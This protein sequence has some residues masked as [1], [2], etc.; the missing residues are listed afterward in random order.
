ML[1]NSLVNDVDCFTYV[2]YER[3]KF[4]LTD[5]DTAEFTYNG[6][7]QKLIGCMFRETNATVHT[8]VVCTAI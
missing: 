4:K 2:T 7:W 8:M 5:V 6:R 3:N 1:W